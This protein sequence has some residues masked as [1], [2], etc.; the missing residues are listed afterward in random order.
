MNVKFMQVDVLVESLCCLWQFSLFEP[1]SQKNLAMCIS[2]VLKMCISVFVILFVL[3]CTFSVYKSSLLPPPSCVNMNLQQNKYNTE[4]RLCSLLLLQTC[5]LVFCAEKSPEQHIRYVRAKLGVC[6]KSLQ[7]HQSNVKILRCLSFTLCVTK[8]CWNEQARSDCLYSG[9]T[10]IAAPA[11]L[12]FVVP[13]L[14]FLSLPRG[15]GDERQAW[16]RELSKEICAA[17]MGLAFQLRLAVWPCHLQPLLPIP[18]LLLSELS[19][20]LGCALLHE[21][22]SLVMN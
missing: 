17:Q 16:V 12:S 20:L 2:A 15:M 18:L 19:L 22:L 6:K 21:V 11:A 10:V 1:S 9:W 8:R 4:C 14:C 13:K 5:K 3:S 7:S